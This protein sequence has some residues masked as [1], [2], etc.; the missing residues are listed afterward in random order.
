MQKRIP[1]NSIL[2]PDAATQVFAGEIFDVFQW[3]Q[4]MYDG[5]LATFEMLRRADTTSTICVVDDALII[6]DEEQPNRGPRCNFPGGRIDPEDA[7]VLSAAQ[8]EVREETGYSFRNWRLVEVRQPY[9]KIEWFVHLFVAWDVM[10][11]EEPVGEPGEKIAQ[12]LVSFDEL[13]QMVMTRVG[14]LGESQ[15]LFESIAS[16]E[17]LIVLPKFVGK[18]VNR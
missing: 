9:A 13:R 2:I 12:R 14:H 1:E 16:I 15:D 5:S 11:Y 4:Q 3:P 17:E 10:G 18:E 7:S 6:L 8:R